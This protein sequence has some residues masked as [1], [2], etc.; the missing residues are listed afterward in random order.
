MSLD[1]P[2]PNMDSPTSMDTGSVFDDMDWKLGQLFMMGFVSDP[3]G[4]NLILASAH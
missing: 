4:L 2:S 1:A 3:R